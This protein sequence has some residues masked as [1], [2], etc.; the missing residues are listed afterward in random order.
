MPRSFS[1]ENP[2]AED[3]FSTVSSGCFKPEHYN[4]RFQRR[5]MT[6]AEG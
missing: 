3:F 4:D 2:A 1:G 5:A 6:A